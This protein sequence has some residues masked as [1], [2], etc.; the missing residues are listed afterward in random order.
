MQYIQFGNY[1]VVEIGENGDVFNRIEYL[2]A[3]VL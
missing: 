2:V 1:E 3:K